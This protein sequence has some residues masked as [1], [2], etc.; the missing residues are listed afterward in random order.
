MKSFACGAV[1]P[2]CTAT[3]EGETDDAILAQVGEHACSAHGL[4]TVPPELVAEV[5]RNI[6]AVA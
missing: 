4:E 6:R 2:N 3:F 5:R 1:V